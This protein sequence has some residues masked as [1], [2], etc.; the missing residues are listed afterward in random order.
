MVGGG[1]VLVDRGM[2]VELHD[3]RL[4]HLQRVAFTVEENEPLGPEDVGVLGP[5]AVMH[6]PGRL[7]D[8]VEGA[9]MTVIAS[10]KSR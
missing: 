6:M 10:P 5:D 7:T 4:S 3:L 9:G 8:L 2:G 1:D